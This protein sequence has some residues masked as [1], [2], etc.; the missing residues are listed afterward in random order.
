M[1][2]GAFVG[3]FSVLLFG[4]L[5]NEGMAGMVL[6]YDELALRLFFSS[7]LLAA[8]GATRNALP[9]ARFRVWLR[10]SVAVFIGCLWSYLLLL[11]AVSF[12]VAGR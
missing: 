10:F 6:R 4:W 5:I 3:A 11:V 7:R 2:L 8:F 9:F 12:S 1:L